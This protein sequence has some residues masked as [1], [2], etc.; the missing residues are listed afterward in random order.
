MAKSK[1]SFKLGVQRI[2]K[3]FGKIVDSIDQYNKEAPKRRKKEIKKLKEEIKI[4]KLK[5]QKK[6]YEPKSKGIF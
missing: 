2:K 1:Y 6:K 4:A 3:G 5:Q